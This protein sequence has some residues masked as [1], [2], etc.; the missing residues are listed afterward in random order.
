[1]KI[2]LILAASM[3]PLASACAMTPAMEEEQPSRIAVPPQGDCDA[4]GVQD[5]I[6]HKATAESGQKLLELTGAR[7]LRWVPPNTA[8]TMDY[9]PDRLT[10]S[11]DQDMIITRISCG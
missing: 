2:A 6:G 9:R 7:T 1:M 11:Y 8:V 10:V 4:S 5:H 3:L